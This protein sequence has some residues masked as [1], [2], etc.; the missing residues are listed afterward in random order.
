MPQLPIGTPQIA[1]L[2]ALVLGLGAL[3]IV[4]IRRADKTTAA[5]TERVPSTPQ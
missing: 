2:V 4:V 5:P 1:L 3:L